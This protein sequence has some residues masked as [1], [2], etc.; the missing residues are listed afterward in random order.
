[1]GARGGVEVGVGVGRGGGGGGRRGEVRGGGN[2]AAA[3]V[4]TWGSRISSR[5]SNISMSSRRSKA[6]AAAAAA[7]SLVW[8]SSRNEKYCSIHET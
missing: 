7:A 1:M 3:V 6:A 8:A 4:R 2:V 5:G